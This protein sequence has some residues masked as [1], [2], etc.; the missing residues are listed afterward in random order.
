[1]LLA[2][3]CVSAQAMYVPYPHPAALC[4]PP[5]AVYHIQRDRAYWGRLWGVLADFWWNHVVP[6]RQEFAAGRWEEVEQYRFVGWCGPGWVVGGGALYRHCLGQN[7]QYM[8]SSW[9]TCTHVQLPS[10]FLS[11][12]WLW[13]LLRNLLPCAGRPHGLKQVRSCGSG[14]SAWRWRRP[15]PSSG[16]SPRHNSTKQR[17]M[18][19]GGDQPFRTAILLCWVCTAVRT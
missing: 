13:L 16:T 18:S 1:M 11:L 4:P 9:P 3:D 17:N 19:A 5:P 2:G 12:P 10:H 14:A 6:A 7:R 15:S 8:G